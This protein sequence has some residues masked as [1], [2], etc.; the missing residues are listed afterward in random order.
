M[1]TYKT[2]GDTDINA[3]HDAFITAFS[4]YQV[5]VD[6]PLD[7]FQNMLKRRGYDG[8]ISMGAFDNEE[9]VGFVL[10]GFRNWH[11]KTTVYD[12]GTGVLPKYRR[13]GITS[14]ML[15][16][17]KKYLKEKN[18]E[19]YLLE[20]I[21]SNISAFELYKKQ[22]FQIT[23]SFQCYKLNK[24]NY[25][26]ISAHET[27][28]IDNITSTCWEHLKEFWDVNP[29]WQNSIDSIDSVQDKFIYSIVSVNHNI[30]GYGI[31][32]KQTGDIPQIAVDNNYRQKGIGRSIL[33]D[34]IKCTKSQKV[35][36]INVDDSSQPINEFLLKTGF[37]Y[38]VPQYEMLLK[39]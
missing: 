36:V 1:Y 20:V 6:L 3:L 4:D 39:L 31:I 26:S 7:F 35:S 5:K 13:Q 23:R 22:G 30:V 12:T 21:K 14:S 27:Q 17:L 37:D 24:N 8:Q 29:S 19:Q 11:G 28:H 9:L 38:G 10:N 32:D 15:E 2:L 34:L 16:N 18:V 25:A 33:T